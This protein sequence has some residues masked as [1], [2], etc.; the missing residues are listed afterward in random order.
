MPALVK[1]ATGATDNSLAR[2]HAM[3]TLEGLDALDAPTVRR[4][5]SA[6]E[7]EVRSAAIRASETLFKKG[8]ASLAE[9]Y[10]RL[11]ADA[12]ATVAIQAMCTMR[13]L[14]VPASKSVVQNCALGKMGGAGMKEIA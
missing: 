3:W 6:K 14:A 2:V 8:D 4:G 9:D 10:V 12:D 11:A 1:L 13:L 5:L 7:P